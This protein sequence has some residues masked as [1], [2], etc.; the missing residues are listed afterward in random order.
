MPRPTARVHKRRHRIVLPLQKR[1]G[2]IVY[3]S[4]PKAADS[5]NS[6]ASR[7][8]NQRVLRARPSVQDVFSRSVLLPQCRGAVLPAWILLRYSGRGLYHCARQRDPADSARRFPP[9]KNLP[10]CRRQFREEPNLFGSKVQAPLR[11]V[12]QFH[13]REIDRSNKWRRFY[14]CSTD[15]LLIPLPAFCLTLKGKHQAAGKNSA[16]VC[17]AL[18]VTDKQ[19]CRFHFTSSFFCFALSTGISSHPSIRFK[20]A[21][22]RAR[23]RFTF[24]YKS[25]IR[26]SVL[27][28][29]L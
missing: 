2:P 24:L 10:T 14:I 6:I 4:C 28:L 25:S 20:I 9:A 1:W 22:C 3:L 23:M 21:S 13:T 15:T 12:K 19:Q 11:S 8:E 17:H 26:I 18:S 27:R 29:T 16:H 7:A 5:A